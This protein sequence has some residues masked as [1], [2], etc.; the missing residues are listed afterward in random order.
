M[1]DCNFYGGCTMEYRKLISFGKNSFVVSLPKPWVIQNKLKKG[2]L[3]YIE[4]NGP[5]LVLS[6][7]EN[8]KENSE[9]TKVI[10][11]D[12]KSSGRLQR[13]VNAAYILNNRRITLKGNELKRNIKRLQQTLQ[14]LIALEVMEQTSDTIIAKDFL[15]MKKVSVDELL[16]KMD[17][18]TRA[19]FTEAR[20]NF[21]KESYLNLSERDN[22]V[23]RL[24]FLLY[25]TI[26]YNLDNPMSAVKNFKLTPAELLSYH[27]CAFYLEKVADEVRRTARYTHQIKVDENEKTKL[28]D[29]LA[30]VN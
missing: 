30:Q 22:D 18:V 24:F 23:N 29:F 4:E 17:V 3:I 12:G 8:Q 2:D 20:E 14:N 15:N 19:M 9:K 1:S 13:E 11:I 5:G 21:T 28:K 16:R 26:L 27:F 6:S 10:N 7:K 25:R